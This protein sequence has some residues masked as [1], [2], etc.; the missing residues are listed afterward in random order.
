MPGQ[1]AAILGY[2][3]DNDVFVAEYDRV[4]SL[5]RQLLWNEQDGI[6]ENGIGMAVSR[7]DSHHELLSATRRYRHNR[8]RQIAWCVRFAQSPG[9]LGQ[10]R[11]SRLLERP[12]ISG[13]I[14][15]ASDIWGLQNYLVYQAIKSY[16]RTEVALE[17]AEKS[18]DL[19]RR[20]GGPSANQRAILCWEKRW[21]R[22]SLHLGR[23]LVPHH[24]GAVH[25]RE[26]LD[27][28][29]LRG[30]ATSAPKVNSSVS[31]GRSIAMT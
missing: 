5:V 31:N 16:G 12:G 29:R 8:H 2:E 6:F 11:H 13:S 17:F 15:L 21:R 24:D 1:I 14:L 20:T 25:R 10:V 30:T 27:G 26:S 9:V 18:Y 4:K 22:R 28:L 23:T 7:R 19:F 3:D